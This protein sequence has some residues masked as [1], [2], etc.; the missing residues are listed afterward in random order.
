M[1]QSKSQK[2]L[3]EK[4]CSKSIYKTFDDTKG[5]TIGS[6]GSQNNLDLIE[7]DSILNKQVVSQLRNGY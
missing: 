2:T 4:V 6:N 1:K 3:P 5:Q 7:V